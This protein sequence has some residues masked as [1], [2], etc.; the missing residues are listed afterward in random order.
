MLFRRRPTPA[1]AAPLS[2]Q[3]LLA[4]YRLRPDV[5][6]LGLLYDRYLPE[7]FAV[8][9]R[10][11]A[12]PDEDAEDAV[13]QLFEHLVEKLKTHAP[14]NFPAW[15]HTTARNHCLMQ[16]RARKRGGPSAG[17]LLLTFPDAADV[18]T[19]AA[20]H[21]P[22]A[23]AEAEDAE[24]AEARLQALE[25]ALAQLPDGQRRCLELFYLE[26]KSY[27]EVAALTG[28]PLAQVKSHLQNGKRMLRRSSPTLPPPP[29][30]APN[31]LL[32]A[33]AAPAGPHPATDML[34]AY[35]AGTLAPAAQQR[36]EAHALACERC[37]DVLAGFSMSDAAGTDRA[38]ASLRR[39]LAAR[40]RQPEPMATP[41][42]RWGRTLAA[43][44]T[45]AAVSV[46]GWWG[47]QQT[48]SAQQNPSAE[49]AMM[50]PA[51]PAPTAPAPA[52]AAAPPLSPG[53][54]AAEAASGEAPVAATF[55][56]ASRPDVAAVAPKAARARGG[57]GTPAVFSDTSRALAVAV[58]QAPRRA[59][60]MKKMVAADAEAPARPDQVASS[61]ASAPD[62]ALNGA[63]ET[64]ADKV[65][66]KETTLK[67]EAKAVTS[68]NPRPRLPQPQRRVQAM[69]P[70]D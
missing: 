34:R 5:A 55:P 47:W 35:A 15:L 24:A 18:E 58:Q 42:W 69:S 36:I 31:P 49:V 28:L 8:C 27:Q 59:S 39:R 21:L 32:A 41:Q 2:D 44:A 3:E 6:D 61:A 25:A 10:Y 64:A 9:R 14:D 12:P 51:P 1:A 23:G 56:A 30:P 7:A 45:L 19:A 11:L 48:H 46:G 50:E 38:V 33:L 66:E 68:Q 40:T 52:V 63:G 16:I 22:D 62:F 29:M 37:A 43:A 17:P 4:R 57:A 26:K 20:R 70:A 13:M 67:E 60:D 53:A 54:P 65:V